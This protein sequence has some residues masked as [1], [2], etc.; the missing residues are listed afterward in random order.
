[1]SFVVF[2]RSPWVIPL[3]IDPHQLADEFAIDIE[4][5]VESGVRPLD[6]SYTFGTRE[7]EPTVDPDRPRRHS[8]SPKLSLISRPWPSYS[9]SRDGGEPVK[10]GYRLAE[11]PVTN[12]S[13]RWF[14][15]E[16]VES[17]E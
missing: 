4:T 2:M 5:A 13:F 15:S 8:A 7:D 16:R 10:L 17:L 1:M 6:P 3:R 11:N 14:P 9:T 12:P